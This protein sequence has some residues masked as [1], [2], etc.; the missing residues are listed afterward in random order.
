MPMLKTIFAALAFSVG[1]WG[2]I[3]GTATISVGQYFNLDT[4]TSG[5]S[6]GDFNWGG[7]SSL[8]PLGGANAAPFDVGGQAG[9][10]LLTPALL[11]SVSAS[12]K[13]ILITTVANEVIGFKTRSG[14]LAKM[15][16]VTSAG[17]SSLT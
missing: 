17:N 11:Q 1:A 16:I 9:Y 10:D 12:F 7:A 15:L 8:V 14:N 2:D 13:T 6:A 4:G 3:S 5:G